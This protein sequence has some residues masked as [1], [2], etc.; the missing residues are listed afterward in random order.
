M[1]T[2]GD[3]EKFQRL[4]QSRVGQERTISLDELNQ[5]LLECAE[6]AGTIDQGPIGL[7]RPER[8][9]E[10]K[11]LIKQLRRSENQEERKRLSKEILKQSRKELRKWRT[12][13]AQHLLTRFKDTKRI[14]KINDEPVSQE[15]CLHNR[16]RSIS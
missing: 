14:H 12:I 9:R 4:L 11:L 7:K 3:P 5:I 8:S 2:S 1:N 13:W 16:A 6:K 15:K 10:L